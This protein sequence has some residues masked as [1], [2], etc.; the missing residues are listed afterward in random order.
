MHIV[1][2]SWGA[3]VQKWEH[4]LYHCTWQHLYQSYLQYKIRK[5]ISGTYKPGRRIL[6]NATRFFRVTPKCTAQLDANH[7][8]QFYSLIMSLNSASTSKMSR[9]SSTTTRRGQIMKLCCFR[10]DYGEYPQPIWEN[11]R[12]SVSR[13]LVH[14]KPTKT[15]KFSCNGGEQLL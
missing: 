9:Q 10:L 15:R 5:Q 7:H 14:L 1:H 8:E 12:E 2:G 3:I 6:L 4:G 13:H 11:L